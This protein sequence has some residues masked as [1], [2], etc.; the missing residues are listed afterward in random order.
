MRSSR[1]LLTNDVVVWERREHVPHH[2]FTQRPYSN[3]LLIPHYII[4][5]QQQW[6]SGAELSSPCSPPFPCT[7]S[8]WPRC[9]CSCFSPPSSLPP[10]SF[11]LPTVSITSWWG[12]YH[13]CC[14]HMSSASQSST[15]IH[16]LYPPC[17]QWWCCWQH[18]L[19]PLV[20]VDMGAHAWSCSVPG[21]GGECQC[22]VAG[23]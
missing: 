13:P 19:A 18:H 8:L 9:R 1:R 21:K 15:C 16:T 4:E 20:L 14:L 7:L 23:V 6:V 22:Q 3:P 17:E 10:L 11:P 12:W 5:L 2:L